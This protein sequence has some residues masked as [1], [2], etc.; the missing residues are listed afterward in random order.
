MV[1]VPSVMCCREGSEA[2]VELIDEGKCRRTTPCFSPSVES[3]CPCVAHPSLTVHD[4][5]KLL[6]RIFLSI[7]NSRIT[8]WKVFCKYLLIKQMNFLTFQLSLLF[9]N[10]SHSPVPL[11]LCLFIFLP[12]HQPLLCSL[13]VS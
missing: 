13:S 6:V 8:T 10:V 9:S 12:I 2:R 4:L 11:V 1:N 5:F 3:Y 7:L